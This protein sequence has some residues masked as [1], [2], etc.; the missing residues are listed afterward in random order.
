[1]LLRPLVALATVAVVSAALVA[2]TGDTD[3]D[4]TTEPIVP[5][6]ELTLTASPAPTET[7]PSPPGRTPPHR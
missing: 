4:E 2:C 5:T 3:E 7:P 6:A 1:M